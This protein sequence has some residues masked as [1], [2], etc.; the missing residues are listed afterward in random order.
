[1]KG[2]GDNNGD[3]EVAEGGSNESGDDADVRDGTGKVC[4]GDKAD[5]DGG[6][7][8]DYD[9]VDD[10]SVVDINEG[11]DEATGGN[12]MSKAD[13]D[14]DANGGNGN[15]NYNGGVDENGVSDTKGGDEGDDGKCMKVPRWI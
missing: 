7:N 12:G 8:N 11:N 15:S 9:D 3:G 13:R 4:C 6:D 10:E 14:D 5:D 2:G 1:M